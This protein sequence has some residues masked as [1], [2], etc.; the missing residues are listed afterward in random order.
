MSIIALLSEVDD[1]FLLLWHLRRNTHSEGLSRLKNAVDP[2]REHLASQGLDLVYR[3][4]K[5]MGPLPL[6]QTD[7]VLMCI[8]LKLSKV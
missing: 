8:S 3:V 5:N 2:E 7:E 1:F 6:S 4:R